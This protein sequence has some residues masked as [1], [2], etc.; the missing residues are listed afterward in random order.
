MQWIYKTIISSKKINGHGIP[1]R[2]PTHNAQKHGPRFCAVERRLRLAQGPALGNS[3]GATQPA[4]LR[5]NSDSAPVEQIG[6]AVNCRRNADEWRNGSLWC[7]ALLSLT[8]PQPEEA[9]VHASS[10]KTP[11]G[12]V[13]DRR[14]GRLSSEKRAEMSAQARATAAMRGILRCQLWGVYTR[15]VE[16]IRQI[17]RVFVRVFF[18][19]PRT[20][21][22]EVNRVE[23][24]VWSPSVT[25]TMFPPNFKR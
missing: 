16:E 12:R 15:A 11:K 24:E 6:S 25:C 18:F 19:P 8:R 17:K 21:T 23:K 3:R 4:E 7:G 9:I 22:D 5:A 10:K 20:E 13:T 14:R 1:R 2:E